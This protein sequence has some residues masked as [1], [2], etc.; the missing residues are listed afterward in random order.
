M[1]L[2]ASSIID[3]AITRAFGITG[4]QKISKAMLLSELSLQ[5]SM[6]V[7]LFVQSA[8]DLLAS[9][10]GTANVTLASNKSGY[11]LTAGIHYRDFTH[12]DTDNVY[13]PITLVQRQSQDAPPRDPAGTLRLVGDQGVFY[14]LDPQRKRWQTS[15]SRVWFDEGS[16]HVIKYSYV[17]DPASLTTLSSALA[18][19]DMAREALISAVYLMIL[20]STPGVDPTRLQMAATARQ[21]AFNSLRWIAYKFHQPAGTRRGRDDQLTES[22]WVEQQLGL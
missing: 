8:P 16:S 22:E 5:N 4:R 2:T 9:V 10:D 18:A 7:Q 3:A 1:S 11:T 20:V 13:T 14:P 17:P 6:I 15:D 21:D 12:V 19:P